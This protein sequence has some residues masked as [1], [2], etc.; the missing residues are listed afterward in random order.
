MG[1]TKRLVMLLYLQNGRRQE[2][3]SR[4]YLE[5]EDWVLGGEQRLRHPNPCQ[6]AHVNKVDI[7]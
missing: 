2:E 4:Y 7:Q 3:A 5:K 6:L 1:L